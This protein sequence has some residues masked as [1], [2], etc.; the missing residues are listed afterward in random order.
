MRRRR[1]TSANSTPISLPHPARAGA[2]RSTS[3]IKSEW[4]PRRSTDDHLPVIAPASTGQSSSHPSDVTAFDR[5]SL[6]PTHQPVEAR[7]HGCLHIGTTRTGRTEHAMTEGT[8]DGAVRALLELR[9][10][11]ERTISE[12]GAAAERDEQ[13]VE[14]RRSGKSWYDIVSSEE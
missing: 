11:L 2:S 7:H 1:T 4:S 14:L 6:K 8:D 13:L 9:A 3:A 5:A 12:L 10:G